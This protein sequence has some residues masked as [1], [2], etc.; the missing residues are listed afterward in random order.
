MGVSTINSNFQGLKGEQHSMRVYLLIF[1]VFVTLTAA[2]AQSD[3]E[4]WRGYFSYNSIKDVAYGDNKVFV[5][6]E[7]AVYTYD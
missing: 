1:G 7:N 3:T 6:A 2:R 5:A 4:L